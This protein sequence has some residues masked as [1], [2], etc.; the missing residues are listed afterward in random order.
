[1]TRTFYTD[2]IVRQRATTVDDGHGNLEPVWTS[3]SELS[4]TGCRV[5]PLSSQEILEHRTAGSQ[6]TFRLLAPRTADVLPEDRVVFES[7]TYEVD[8]AARR[9]RSP[10]G[11]ANH[12][13]I[14]LRRFDG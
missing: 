3:P 7:V 1:M 2:I 6:V 10:T 4:I 5:Q 11:V 9:H 12:A 13:E 8:G 14:L